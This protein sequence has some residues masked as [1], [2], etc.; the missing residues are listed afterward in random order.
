VKGFGSYPLP[1]DFVLSGVFLNV[2][3]V[4]YTAAYTVNNSAIAPSLG[5]NLSA[6]GAAA[7]CS[8]TSTV[9]LFKD[10]T[11]FEPRRSQLDLRVS[12]MLAVRQGMR[13]QLNLDAYNVFNS[14][15]VLIEIGTYGSRWRLP[16]T[17]RDARI[18]QF[19]GTL[20]F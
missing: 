4:A 2:S 16:A 19:G 1:G 18:F 17:I 14:S 8:A 10:Q 11:Q 12:K 7:V 20:N 15:A 9:P 6:C 5:R 3:G 13:L